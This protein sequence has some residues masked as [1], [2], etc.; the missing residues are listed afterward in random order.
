M[1]DSKPIVDPDLSPRRRC[2]IWRAAV[3][4]ALVLVGVTA[5]NSAEKKKESAESSKPEHLPSDEVLQLYL[6]RE[7]AERHT[8]DVRKDEV[9]AADGVTFGPQREGNVPP[10]LARG[11]CPP[12]MVAIDRDYCVDRFEVSLVDSGSGRTLSPHYPPVKSLTVSIYEHWVEQAP[13]SRRTMGREIHIPPPPAFELSEN[14]SPSARSLRDALPA[15]YL[16][17]VSSDTACKNAG[18]RLCSREEWVRA[19]RGDQ[20]TKFPYG[21]EYRPGACNVH[22]QSHPARLLH[23]DASRNH[24]DPRLGLTYDADGPLLLPTGSKDQ[25]LSHWGDDAIYDMVGN[26]DEWIDDPGGAFLGGFFSRGTKSGCDASI[27]SHAPSY[28]DY[29]LGTRCCETQE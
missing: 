23:G 26:I 12:D 2:T 14:F 17:R 20:G 16:S 5:C 28:F 7:G 15:G 29:S 4:P 22:R 21:N 6:P 24:T 13:F 1:I 19:C 27:D 11:P 3:L 9:D 10:L 18:K 25:C 8:F